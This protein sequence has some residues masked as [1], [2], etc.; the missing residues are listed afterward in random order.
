[1]PEIRFII[2]HCK[3]C[4]AG[5]KVRL[6]RINRTPFECLTCGDAVALAPYLPM[7]ETIHR[8]SE[9]VVRIEDHFLLDGDTLTPRPGVTAAP[10]LYS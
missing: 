9:I 4:G 10:S 2:V 6:E 7:L 5:Y 1:M 8:Y 3:H